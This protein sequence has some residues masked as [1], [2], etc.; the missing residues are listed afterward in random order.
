MTLA[1]ILA[2]LDQA[3]HVLEASRQP[4]FL[5]EACSEAIALL[6]AKEPKP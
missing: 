1:E 4:Y 3:R 5:G 6:K 2:G